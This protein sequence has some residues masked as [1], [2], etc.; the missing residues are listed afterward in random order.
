MAASI[1]AAE[2]GTTGFLIV[3][4]LSLA[5]GPTRL[6]AVHLQDLDIGVTLDAM[7]EIAISPSVET[8]LEDVR[9]TKRPWFMKLVQGRLA[10]RAALDVPKIASGD[11]RA[12][13]RAIRAAAIKAALSGATAGMVSTGAS[14]AT[15]QTE[16]IAGLVAIPVA[17]LAMGADSVV[18]SVVQVELSWDLAVSYGVPFDAKDEEDVWRLYALAFGT[19]DHEDKEDAGADLVER[20]G[21]VDAEEIGEQIGHKVLGESVLR[22]IVPVLGIAISAVTNYVRTRKFGETL[23]RYMRYQR[24]LGDALDQVTT[25]CS[26][27]TELLIEGIWFLFSA[28]GKLLPEEAAVLASRMR[29]LDPVTKQALTARFVEDEADWLDRIGRGVP[30]EKS[31][32]FFEGLEVAAVVDKM[33]GLPERRILRAA[34]RAL[35][36]PF[37][38]ERLERMI[39]QL[40]ATGVLSRETSPTP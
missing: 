24:A 35:G 29:S 16:G 15:A 7:S 21:H 30:K 26:S 34:A 38:P 2:D 23:R 39:A 13:D 4:D 37:R 6:S 12:R 22:N 36:V 9:A 19:H 32:A 14:L 1:G 18:R 20:V 27:Q 8:L 5:P 33:V 11:P 25:E 31:A 17:A 40:D 10:K 3:T 28:D